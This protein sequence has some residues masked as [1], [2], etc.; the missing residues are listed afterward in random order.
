MLQPASITI[1]SLHAFTAAIEQSGTEEPTWYRG[2]G[3]VSHSLQPSLYRRPGL[4]SADEYADLEDELNQRFRE[5]SIPYHTLRGTSADERSWETLFLMQHFGVPTRLLDW[6]EN[7]FL[8]LLFA[9]TSAHIDAH[10]RAASADACVWALQPQAWNRLALSDITYNGD[11]LSV[12]K[13][14]LESYIPGRSRNLRRK[15]PVA[16]Y[17]LYNS[18]RIA[19]QKGVF[20]IFGTGTAPMEEEA[21]LLSAQDTLKRYVIPADFVVPMLDAL[22]TMGFTDSMIYPDLMGLALE[23][24]RKFG[25]M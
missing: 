1:D 9:M 6:T 5:R 18:A 17:G 15:H 21:A 25:Y 4:Q 3:N 13:A 23:L 11:I 24:K 22:G 8:G 14:E 10:T 12:D 16:M 20:T 7:P 2:C 19:A